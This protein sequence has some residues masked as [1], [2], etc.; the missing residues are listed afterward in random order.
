MIIL[1]KNEIDFHRCGFLKF[2]AMQSFLMHLN[3]YFP[4]LWMVASSV[5]SNLFHL[6]E[7][8]GSNLWKLFIYKI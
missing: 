4:T 2:S 6:F 5:Y 3:Y 8:S 7:S 1:I